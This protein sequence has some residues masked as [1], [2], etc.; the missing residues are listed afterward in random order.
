MRR[1]ILLTTLALAASATVSADPVRDRHGD[2][3]RYHRDR[4]NYDRFDNSYW[5]NNYY[6][7][8]VPL[9][10]AYTADARRQFINVRGRADFERL[11]IESERGAP[12]S[13][14]GAVEYTDGSVQKVRFDARL[15]RMRQLLGSPRLAAVRW[16]DPAVAR[17]R[18]DDYARRPTWEGGRWLFDLASLEEWLQRLGDR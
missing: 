2:R 15:P 16:G 12:V 17:A 4:D 18:L 5:R 11:R 14:Q 1:I 6:R 9:A 10:R 8:W 7:R 13:N 3:D